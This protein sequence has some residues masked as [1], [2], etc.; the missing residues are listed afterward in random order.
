M[1][2]VALYAG[3]YGGV[4]RDEQPWHEFI[5][6]LDRI[7]ALEARQ[8]LAIAHGTL[9]GQPVDSAQMGMRQLEVLQVK[10]LASF[11]KRP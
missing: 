11:E 10:R 5:A 8:R 9:L 2:L 7:P 6:L 3:Q 4:P 1:T